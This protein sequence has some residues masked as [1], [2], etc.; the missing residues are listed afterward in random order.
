MDRSRTKS[1]ADFYLEFV[2]EIQDVRVFELLR[3]QHSIKNW[4]EETLD[5]RGM[6]DEDLFT[7]LSS[8]V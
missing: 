3:A 6:L 2:G 4:I 7:S 8:G 1:V 5:I